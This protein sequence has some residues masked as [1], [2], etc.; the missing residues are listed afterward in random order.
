MCFQTV[1]GGLTSPLNMDHLPGL[2]RTKPWPPSHQ[3]MKGCLVHEGPP[4][5]WLS[6]LCSR[7]HSSHQSAHAPLWRED[8]SEITLCFLDRKSFVKG[9]EQTPAYENMYG[10]DFGHGGKDMGSV[11][12]IWIHDGLSG[13]IPETSES[14]VS[15]EW[16]EIIPRP[17]I[18]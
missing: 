16:G 5:H 2:N 10:W 13:T 14:M 9:L 17:L 11:R 1:E 8:Q 12:P 18:H 4:T 15:T 7:D 3:E 6:G